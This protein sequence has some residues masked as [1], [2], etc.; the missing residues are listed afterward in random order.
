MTCWLAWALYPVNVPGFSGVVCVQQ[1]H[2]SV[3]TDD[4]SC[5]EHV[6]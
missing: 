5:S 2:E 1:G 4:F 6:I 3:K